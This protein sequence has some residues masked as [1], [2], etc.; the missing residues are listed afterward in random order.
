MNEVGPGHPHPRLHRARGHRGR[1]AA[2]RAA[3]R[4][5]PP[6][7]WTPACETLPG[8]AAEIL[9]DAV[10][11]VLCPDK[12]NTEEWLE[13][14]R[15]AHSVGLRSNVTI[16]F[17]VD[18]AAP[19]AGPATSCAPASLQKE[20][21]G[22]TEFV[23]L[24]FVH[25]AAPIY[26]QHKARRGPDVPRGAAHARRRPHR[27]PRLDRQ[28][29]GVVGE[30]RATAA[31]RQMLQAGAN[32]L[33]G[34]LMD[35]N[36]SRA[37]GASPRH[38]DGRGRL[39]ELGRAAR[40]PAR[41]AHH[42]LRP[43][44]PGLTPPARHHHSSS[45]LAS[46]SRTCSRVHAGT[47]ARRPARSSR[48]TSRAEPS[49][50]SSS[51]RRT[52]CTWPRE[53][54]TRARLTAMADDLG[55]CSTRPAPRQPRRPARHPAHRGGPGR[56]RRRPPRP[57]DHRRRAQGDAGRVRDLRAAR[58]RPEG[59]DLRLGPHPARRP[60]LRPGPRPRPRS[61]PS[62]GWMVDHR[63]RA[64]DHGAGVEGAGPGPGHRRQH[65]PAV[66]GGAERHPRRRRA[67]S[68]R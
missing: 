31:P 8:T 30:D 21:G 18:R 9:D 60:A 6:A 1:Q 10:R 47:G 61:W 27:L 68:W 62:A 41:A 2:R 54:R 50:S 45:S 64:R 37:A 55:S 33:G 13:A 63:R 42:A 51:A 46:M 66:R 38:D 40:P 14:H 58:G 59:D 5:P 3:G 53:H 39:P 7:A 15:T 26:L 67:A 36:I 20:T 35:E 25:M 43:P 49:P 24:P 22:F 23:P 12:I 52:G 4:L 65:P 16:M 57:Q 28:H 32:D 48:A 34:T 56:R 44:G 17:G 29:P 11:A 19:L